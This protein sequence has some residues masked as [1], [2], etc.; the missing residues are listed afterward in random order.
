[1]PPAT[2]TYTVHCTFTT[3][4]EPL[5]YVPRATLRKALKGLGANQCRDIL[6]GNTSPS[7]PLMTLPLC[8]QFARTLGGRSTTSRRLT[9]AIVKGLRDSNRERRS[10]GRSSSRPVADVREEEEDDD[11]FYS[12]CDYVSAK[13][14]GARGTRLHSSNF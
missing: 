6:F 10:E 1:M 3:G 9:M 7:V 5:P 12:D 11:E 13:W 14:R 2:F 8:R 4:A